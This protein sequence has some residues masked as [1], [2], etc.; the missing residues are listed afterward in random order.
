M[1]YK[2]NRRMKEKRGSIRKLGGRLGRE[3]MAGASFGELAI[4]LGMASKVI[5]QTNGHTLTLSKQGN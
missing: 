3:E 4:H 5:D 2:R 1:R